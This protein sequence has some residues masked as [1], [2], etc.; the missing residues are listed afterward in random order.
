MESREAPG[1]GWRLSRGRFC[2]FSGP[3][4]AICEMLSPEG[5]PSRRPL[6]FSVSGVCGASSGRSSPCW[7]PGRA[8]CSPPLS[9]SDPDTPRLA[10][11]SQN[12]E[13]RDGRAAR[14]T[15]LLA[16]FHPLGKSTRA[17]LMPCFLASQSRPAPAPGSSGLLSPSLVSG[18]SGCAELGRSGA[19]PREGRPSH[20]SGVVLSPREA[21]HS[22]LLR[23]PES[24]GSS[25]LRQP[26]S[27]SALLPGRWGPRGSAEGRPAG[28]VKREEG[29]SDLCTAASLGPLPHAFCVGP[30]PVRGHPGKG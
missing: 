14:A 26:C 20:S 24:A 21:W 1:L 3:P 18:S 11:C 6:C 8:L 25:E 30:Q 2:P 9:A 19:Q 15:P 28:R 12:A 5:C 22:L 4:F 27:D 29:G 16:H 10:L 17:P 7:P 23:S 13:E